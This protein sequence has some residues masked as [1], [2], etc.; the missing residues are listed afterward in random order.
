MYNNLKLWKG[1]LK[2]G[3]RLKVYLR[4]NTAN[5]TCI[6]IS[7]DMVGYGFLCPLSLPPAVQW[8][9]SACLW[10]RTLKDLLGRFSNLPVIFSCLNSEQPNLT[11]SCILE[12][13]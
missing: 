12:F 3:V 6:L 9:I 13:I 11:Y 10:F 7:V 8:W 1:G 4:E 5:V 2:K